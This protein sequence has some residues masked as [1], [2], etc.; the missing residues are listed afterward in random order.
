M[1]LHTPPSLPVLRSNKDR[2]LYFSFFFLEIPRKFRTG[3]RKSLQRA[4]HVAVNLIF[5]RQIVGSILLKANF[6]EK[7]RMLLVEK[8]TYI[9][10]IIKS[11]QL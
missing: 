7:M 8:S 2:A 11:N 6:L 1:S 9:L 3:S 4:E 10:F 5:G